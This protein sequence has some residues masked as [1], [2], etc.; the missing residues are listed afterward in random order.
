MNLSPF[1]YL[2][3]PGALTVMRKLGFRTFGPLID[4]RYDQVDDPGERLRMIFLELDRV[5]SMPLQA[6]HQL[7]QDLWPVLEHNYWHFY[8]EMPKAFPAALQTDVFGPL[9]YQLDLGTAQAAS[10]ITTQQPV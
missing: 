2:G 3:N 9:G 10:A 4:E 8:R 6:L 1:V 5:L 7:Y